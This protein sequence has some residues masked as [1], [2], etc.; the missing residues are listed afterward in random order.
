MLVIYIGSTVAFNALV[1]SYVVLSTSSYM[2]A[3][4]VH[5]FTGRKRIAPGWFHMGY[6]PTGYIVNIMAL[7]YIVV[8]NVFFCLPFSAPPVTPATMNY[9]SLVSYGMCILIL[10]WWFIGGN[11][12]YRGPKLSSETLAVLEGDTAHA[13]GTLHGVSLVSS[14]DYGNQVPEMVDSKK[15]H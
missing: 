13:D 11:K 14:A 6:G 3:I 9:T 7:T 1:G 10:V 2:L 4:G 5:L 8:S 12:S 15:V